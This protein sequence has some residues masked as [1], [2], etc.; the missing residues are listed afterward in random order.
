MFLTPCWCSTSCVV[1]MNS[2]SMVTHVGVIFLVPSL[3]CMQGFLA[4]LRLSLQAATFSLSA[5]SRENVRCVAQSP[6]VSTTCKVTQYN[7]DTPEECSSPPYAKL[8]K[9]AARHRQSCYDGYFII[10]CSTFHFKLL[11]LLFLQI[12]FFGGGKM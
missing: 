3:P 12:L 8:T 9:S 7:S 6:Q 2:S 4:S 11:L 10:I 5:Q 1:W